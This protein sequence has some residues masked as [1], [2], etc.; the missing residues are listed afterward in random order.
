MILRLLSVLVLSAPVIFV[1]LW[2]SDN[3]GQV[4]VE[5]LGWRIE[6]NVP[7]FLVVLLAIFVVLF[8]IE[9]GLSTIASLPIRLRSTRKAKGVEKGL[10]ALVASLDAAAAGDSEMGRRLGAEA[11]RHLGSADLAQRLDRLMPKPV[12][13]PQPPKGTKKAGMRE[14]GIGGFFRRLTGR[15]TLSAHPP[16]SPAPSPSKA[17]LP[18]MPAAASPPPPVAPASTPL[19]E[20]GLDLAV[21][22]GDWSRALELIDAAVPCPLHWRAMILTAQANTLV[23][24]APDQARAVTEQAVTADP[25][26]L[27]AIELALRLD[28]AANR[29]AQAE[30]LLSKIW[31]QTPSFRFLE[32]C[33]PLWAG[34]KGEAC[35][36]RVDALVKS[37][38]DHP[39]SHLAKGAAAMAAGHWGPAR[40]HLVAAIKASPS[41]RAFQ[42]MSTVEE[43]DGGDAAAIRMW[44]RRAGDAANGSA[45]RCAQ[46]GTD[47]SEWAI[48]C[49]SCSAIGKIERAGKG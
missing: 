6:T 28:V 13:P 14:A 37:N 19:D 49:P 22:A 1:T 21:Q 34:E 16:E 3:S 7:V 25:S 27:P 46:C 10:A 30:E 2:F 35:I 36:A 11:A 38:P 4:A 41:A 47:H 26:F 32:L 20:A 29:R 24:S 15:K 17:P 31:P 39:E 40:L 8:L 45:W 43:K 18:R 9:H 33:T 23:L 12:E 48:L 5:W 42:L 44:L